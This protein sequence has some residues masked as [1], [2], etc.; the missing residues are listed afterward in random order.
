MYRFGPYLRSG[1]GLSFSACRFT[2]LALLVG[3]IVSA[4]C[5]GASVAPSVEAPKAQLPGTVVPL[6]YDLELTIDPRKE[7]FSG[8]ASVDIRVEEPTQR[9]WIHGLGL[10]VSSTA[11]ELPGRKV[12]L[13]YTAA[14]ELT[15]VARLDAGER[16]DRGSGRLRVAY[17]ASFSSGAQGLFRSQAAGESYVFSQMEPT[18]LRGVPFRKGDRSTW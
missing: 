8:I 11:L 3:C 7:T 6:A 13:A 10:K 16:I 12:P 1:S 18:D 4:A 15:G 14:D 5:S 2:T 17:T 9:I